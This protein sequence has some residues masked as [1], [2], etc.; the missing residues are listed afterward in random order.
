MHKIFLSLFFSFF[1]I[2]VAWG[3]TIKIQAIV[4]DEVITNYDVEQRLKI[5][6]LTSGAKFTKDNIDFVKRQILESLIIERVKNIQTQKYN[7][8]A[9]SAEV[10]MLFQNIAKDNEM[11]KAEFIEFLNSKDID[12]DIFK[13]Q[14]RDSLNWQTLILTQIKPLINVSDYEL[15][16]YFESFESRKDG[17]EYLV[18]IAEFPIEKTV[19]VK[20]TVNKI[21]NQVNRNQ[22]EFS[23]IAKSFKIN[24]SSKKEHWKYKNDFPEEMQKLI[25]NLPVGTV[26]KPVKIDNSYYLIYLINKRPSSVKQDNKAAYQNEI[27]KKL[28]LNK[29]ERKL[30]SYLQNLRQNTFIEIKKS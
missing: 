12:I 6:I 18:E 4:G 19:N 1:L 30:K 28:F 16:N 14:I 27:Y 7:I 9:S 26:A 21:Y 15:A 5:I 17:Y 10:E 3:D 22:L 25:A 23:S 29:L 24:L 8:F 2:S 20:K 11:S 13:D